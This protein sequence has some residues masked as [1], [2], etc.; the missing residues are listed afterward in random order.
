MELNHV[1]NWCHWAQVFSPIPWIESHQLVTMSALLPF[2][3]KK[4]ASCPRGPRGLQPPITAPQTQSY[5][6]THVSLLFQTS[7]K[8]YWA[9]HP[10]KY[11]AEGADRDVRRSRRANAQQ[12]TKLFSLWEKRRSIRRNKE[13]RHMMVENNS[14][15]FQKM[16]IIEIIGHVLLKIKTKA[17]FMLEVSTVVRRHT[18]NMANKQ[19]LL[20]VKVQKHSDITVKITKK[21]FFFLIIHALI[22]NDNKSNHFSN[23]MVYLYL[24]FD[25]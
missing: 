11:R 16:W 17:L 18:G 21:Y 14:W 9:A 4:D 6:T 3:Q 24:Y 5:S 23:I 2:S 10:K 8:R 19:D 22:W 7:L 1:E 13:K 25:K 15:I 20:V 12:Q